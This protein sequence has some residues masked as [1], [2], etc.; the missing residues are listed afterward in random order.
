MRG[1][2][3]YR[4]EMGTLADLGMENYEYENWEYFGINEANISPMQ[5]DRRSTRVMLSTH[6]YFKSFY[7]IIV[8]V[9]I[10]PRRKNE[11]KGMKTNK[12]I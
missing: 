11:K 2:E 10:I 6:P 4:F 7:F 12:Y 8:N 3:R 9:T 1:K 5:S